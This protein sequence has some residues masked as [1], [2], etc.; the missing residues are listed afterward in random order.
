MENNDISAS[1]KTEKISGKLKIPPSK[2]SKY[3]VFS[4]L[5]FPV[6]SPSIVKYGPEK[7]PYLDTFRAMYIFP[8]F[9]CSDS[10]RNHNTY[11]AN[12]TH[13]TNEG[14]C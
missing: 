9:S 5:Y 11:N 3:G 8:S 12:A 14:N 10:P 2:V 13:N 4:G 7:N 1:I 6:F